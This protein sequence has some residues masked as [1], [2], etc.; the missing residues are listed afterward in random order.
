MSDL[1]LVEWD[2]DLFGE[3]FT[4]LS[5]TAAQPVNSPLRRLQA[6]LEDA[7]PWLLALTNLP[8]PNDQDKN[9]VEKGEC[10][11]AYGSIVRLTAS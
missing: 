11:M 9:A 7:K 3:L 10:Q 6:R 5:R 4:L 2:H 1:S 8:G